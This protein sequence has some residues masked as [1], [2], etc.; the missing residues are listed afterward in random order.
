MDW[1]AWVASLSGEE[2]A[3]LAAAITETGVSDSIG[4]EELTAWIRFWFARIHSKKIAPKTIASYRTSIEQYIVPAIGKVRLGALTPQHVRDVEL[5]IRGRGLGGSTAQQA[6]RVLSLAL[7]D[8]MRDGRVT[9]NVATLVD[10]PKK[11][12]S[13]MTVL[14]AEGGIRLLETVQHDRLGSRVAAA[15]LTGARQGEL[16]G[17]ELDRVT[18]EL[19]LSWQLKRFSWSHG[20]NRAKP[21]ESVCRAKQGSKCPDRHLDAPEDQEFRHLTGGLW[22]SRPK[23]AAGWRVV[24]LVEPLRSIV[25]RRVQVAAEEPNPHGLLWSSDPKRARG[26]TALD[27]SPVDPRVDNE[28]WHSVLER[29]GLPNATLHS[30]RHT[31]VDLLYAAESVDEVTIAEIVGHSTYLMSRKYRSRGNRDTMRDALRRAYQPLL[32]ASTPTTEG[33]P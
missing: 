1:T 9:R 20:C 14:D 23:S 33:T 11:K 12:T 32:A 22:L 25:E 13:K 18:D 2:R 7:R 30:A 6:H 24:P 5:C 15:L 28:Y 17:L 29:A 8:A 3:S 10:Q 21:W 31:T 27:G 4:S 26:G 19:D 16:L